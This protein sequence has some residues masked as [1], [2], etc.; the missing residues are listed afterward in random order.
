MQNLAIRATLACLIL[1]GFAQAQEKDQWVGMKVVTKYRR[2]PKVDG[3]EVEDG[4]RMLFY[5]VERT[6]GDHLWVVSKGVEGWL[7]AEDVVPLDRAVDFF[8]EEIRS[9]PGN[10][11]AYEC[12]GQV[13]D[14]LDD[15]DGA[16]AD[17][18]EAIRL[19]P[20]CKRLYWRRGEILGD[21]EEYD[22][23][24]ADF[25]EI[26]RL[27]SKDPQ[28]YLGRGMIRGLK[29]EYDRGLVDINEA[30]RLDPKDPDVYSLRGGFYY[31]MNDFDRALADYTAAIRLDPIDDLSFEFRGKS[32]A[33]K[34]EFDRAVA[35]LDEAIRIDPEEADHHNARAMLWAACP[36]PKFRDGK[37]AVEAATK[38]CELS[39]WKIPVHI[40]T[41]AAAFAEAGHFDEAVSME[42]KALRLEAADVEDTKAYQGR[43]ALYLDK[44]PYR[45]P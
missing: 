3:R 44:K 30:A 12:L 17:F 1:A 7:R 40:D 35:D 29:K 9:D 6:D 8:T 18:T 24:I 42:R 22:R 19:D 13:R 36:D 20:K 39:S 26:I 14:K 16:L 45:E 43:L 33:K 34:H 28:G 5:A 31:E 2:P 37:K 41:L 4:S 15:L 23:A 11:A 38:A 25:E 32:L 10:A 21:K 27:D